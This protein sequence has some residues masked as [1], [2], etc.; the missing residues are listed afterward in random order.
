MDF[1][2]P[3]VDDPYLFGG[4]AAANSLSD[5]YAMGGTPLTAMNIVCFPIDTAP[6]EMLGQ[7][8]RGG[9]DKTTE[10]GAV[11]VG[12]HSV[13]DPEPKFGMAVTGAVHPSKVIANSSA[14]PGDRIVLTKAIGTGVVTTAAKYDDCEPEAF[15]A[16][17]NSMMTLNADASAAAV[18]CDVR[19]GT[20]ITGFGLAGHL[21]RLALASGVGIE[22]SAMSIPLFPHMKEMVGRGHVTRGSVQGFEYLGN[23]LVAEN[24]E[25]SLLHLMFDPQTSGGLALCVSTERLERL[26]QELT[27][28][29]VL[30][31]AV[32]GRVTDGP[33]M[34]VVRP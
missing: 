26:I 13:E 22:I 24:V 33:P 21:Y 8:L 12:G 7:I 27:D 4:I 25:E 9:Y 1:F 30:V 5:I 31:R 34:V 29:Q 10:S 3:I 19:A 18:A 2:T 28:R 20:D 6:P 23:S 11:L 14:K 32:I 16:A 15:E 17:C